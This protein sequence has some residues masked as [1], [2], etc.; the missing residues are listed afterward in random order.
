[1]VSPSWSP[2]LLSS[3]ELDHIHSSAIEL[4]ENV[5]LGVDHSGL[6][7]RLAGQE[8]VRVE[9]K[10]V[11]FRGDHIENALEAMQFPSSPPPYVLPESD[12]LILDQ[13]YRR[14]EAVI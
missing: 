8:G 2:N 3:G 9:G 1:M 5:G 4:G 14:V 12:R 10:R 13:I 6:L 7:K 11:H